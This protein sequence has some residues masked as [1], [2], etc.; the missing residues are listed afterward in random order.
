MPTIS[1]PPILS[2]KSTFPKLTKFPREDIWI[3]ISLPPPP[4]P[5]HLKNF[6]RSLNVFTQR[7]DEKWKTIWNGEEGGGGGGPLLK[8]SPRR[9]IEFSKGRRRIRSV[10]VRQT[11]AYYLASPM[12][13][14]PGVTLFLPFDPPLKTRFLHGRATPRKDRSGT[15]LLASDPPRIERCRPTKDDALKEHLRF[16][17]LGCRKPTSIE[18]GTEGERGRTMWNESGKRTDVTDII[19]R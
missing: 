15:F 2:L 11:T 6:K 17:T 13:R 14:F 10:F 5:I 1:F 19:P 12:K 4:P 8:L 16:D 9:G 3:S 7:F 18:R